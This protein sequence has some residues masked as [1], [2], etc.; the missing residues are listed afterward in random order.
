MQLNLG[1]IIFLKLFE[2][3]VCFNFFRDI[4]ALLLF[5]PPI[6]SDIGDLPNFSKK[7]L[8]KPILVANLKM[9]SL[10]CNYKH[11]LH[12]N[13]SMPF[14]LPLQPINFLFGLILFHTCAFSG[15]KLSVL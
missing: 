13:C 9:I 2:K 12:C 14:S 7:N 1:T 3:W 4:E 11:N 5:Q 6:L 8:P 10:I 15:D